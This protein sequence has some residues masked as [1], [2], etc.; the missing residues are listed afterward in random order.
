MNLMVDKAAKLYK[1]QIQ[2]HQTLQRIALIRGEEFSISD[3]KK[4]GQRRLSS[5][6]NDDEYD[7]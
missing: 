6:S 7:S 1:N 5:G 3:L 4:P 2:T